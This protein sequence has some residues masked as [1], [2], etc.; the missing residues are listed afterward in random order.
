MANKI[1]IL[2]EELVNKIAAGEVVERPASVLKELVE[3][4]IDAGATRIAVEI[5]AGGKQSIRVVDNGIGMSRDDAILSIERHGTSKIGAVS[6]L[7]GIATLGFRGEALS[8]I[9]A[10]SRMTLDTRQAEDMVG[11]K[12]VLEGGVLRD[13]SEIGR[14]V[15]TAVTVRNLFFNTPARRKFLRGTET[16]MRHITQCL[17]NFTLAHPEIGFSLVHNGRNVLRLNPGE[18]SERMEEIFGG[19]LME[20]TIPLDF[21]KEGIRVLGF[22]GRPETAR[23]SRAHQVVF[24]NRRPIVNRT[25]SHAVHA[26]YGS[27]LSKR[28]YPFFSVF[29]EVD[30]TAV[31]VNVHP[32][33]REVRFS[34]ERR[35]HDVLADGVRAALRD[36]VGV[37]ERT[38]SEEMIAPGP[39][40]PSGQ[41]S[42]QAPPQRGLHSGGR[43]SISGGGPIPAAQIHESVEVYGT[44]SADP[45]DFASQMS[46]TFT[47]RT[48]KEILDRDIPQGPELEEVSLDEDEDLASV[49][50]LHRKYI[51]AHVKDGIVLIDQHVAHERIIYEEMMARLEGAGGTAQQL[52]F[53]L[54]L[55]LSVLEYEILNASIPM[56]TKMGFG[57]RPFGRQTM[58]VDAIPAELKTWEN[59]DVLRNIAQ[60]LSDELGEGTSNLQERLV[61]SYACHTGIKA[62]DRMDPREMRALIDRLFATKTP[63]VCPHGRPI[64]IRMMVKEID[65]M[66]GR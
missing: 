23:E 44:R 39:V 46:L 14:D 33:K 41:P 22:L 20:Q 28:S 27:A 16:E 13:V 17:I 4:A 61:T 31:D 38:L 26:G 10:V 59:G 48:E 18:L 57:I 63:F 32:T 52:L 11:T 64:V 55:E 30:P 65:R 60:D 9:G 49:W 12:V 35:V 40:L 5:A 37:P 19:N 34:D 2:S 45:R 21:D 62:G 53:P 54:T 43:T 25:I 47:A 29:L 66:F 56:L 58:I 42:V 15:G 1:H 7:R 8:S 36:A 51:L 6:D 24:L 50:Q 3:N